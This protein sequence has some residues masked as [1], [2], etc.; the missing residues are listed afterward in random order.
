MPSRP[1][2]FLDEYAV[3]WVRCARELAEILPRLEA[4]EAA[5]HAVRNK[6]LWAAE[7]IVATLGPG[8]ECAFVVD[9]AVL[10]VSADR[11]HL[12]RRGGTGS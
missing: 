11:I 7:Q 6:Q 4:V 10:I 5:H 12:V 2:T 8:E 1:R 3:L 9:D